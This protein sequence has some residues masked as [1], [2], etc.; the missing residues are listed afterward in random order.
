MVSQIGKMLGSRQFAMK[1]V[2]LLAFFVGLQQ[3]AVLLRESRERTK[4]VVSMTHQ[5]ALE[6]TRLPSEQDVL[7]Y[8]SERHHKEMPAQK[9]EGV[10]KKLEMTPFSRFQNTEINNE[11]ELISSEPEHSA[12][13]I[14]SPPTQKVQASTGVT[15]TGI[16]EKKLIFVKFHQV[17]GTTV[18]DRLIQNAKDR[19]LEA[20]CR[21]GCD[22]CAQHASLN[23]LGGCLGASEKRV[24]AIFREPVDKSLARFYFQASR[25]DY[26]SG[27]AGFEE[28]IDEY[29]KRCS[30]KSRPAHRQCPNEYTQIL[31]KGS[32]MNAIK[33]LRALDVVG[34]TE[35]FDDFMVVLAYRMNW[36]LKWVTY[37]RLKTV[38]DRPK[39][40]DHTD[41]VLSA[42][43]RAVSDDSAVYDAA[44]EIAT[45]KASKIPFINDLRASFQEL[46]SKID[47]TCQFKA[48]GRNLIGK[49][50]YAMARSIM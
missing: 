45:D 38:L 16:P 39:V 50:C 30:D 27:I 44:V 25:N 10:L 6:L 13:L 35:N 11:T 8:L 46:Q 49:D 4:A 41:A 36:P 22:V 26:E 3:F 21:A 19:N 47:Q 18:A 32:H 14:I 48:H 40:S 1:A 2:I 20:C 33:E 7:G 17:G 43:R 5:H 12:S 28:H 37:K 9:K 42:L 24:V 29:V 31:G 15:I 34:T 23:C